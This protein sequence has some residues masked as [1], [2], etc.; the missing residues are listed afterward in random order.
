MKAPGRRPMKAKWTGYTDRSYYFE[1]QNIETP[2]PDGI[3]GNYVFAR[4]DRSK[5][6]WVPV[7]IGKGE[8]SERYDE[9]MED[10]CVTGKATHYHWHENSEKRKHDREEA[11]LIHGNPECMVKYGGCNK[12]QPSE[13][14]LKSLRLPSL[15]RTLGLE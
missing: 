7:Y 9:A 3:D 5:S 4:W 6:R 15:A 10:R 1:V 12:R 13:K 2:P 14:T 11:D 8:L